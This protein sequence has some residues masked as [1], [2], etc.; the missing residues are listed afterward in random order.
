MWLMKSLV[1]DH[2]TI[3]NFRRDNPKAIR[4]VFRA[5][6]QLAKHFDLIGGK[7]VAGDS[8]KLRAQNSKKNNFNEAKIERHIAYI[9]AK[10]EEYSKILA[11][12]D[13]E[14]VSDPEKTE[15]KEKI[16]KH[17]ER[18]ATYQ[19]LRQ[20]LELSG[21]TQISTSDPESRQLVTRNNIT[22]VGYSVQTTVD[23]KHNIPID[24]KV[25]NQNDNK[26]MGGMV[27]RAKT[28]LQNND[29]TA[30]YD[31]GYHTGG[32]FDYAHKQGIEV[33]VAIPDPGSQAPDPAFNVEHFTYD[34]ISDIYTCPAG[35]TLSSN[36][37]QYDKNRSKTSHKVKHYKTNQC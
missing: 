8:T 1:P 6:V 25:T 18:K 34:K 27:R 28:I 33:L 12:E 24:F 19:D 16:K 23:A 2:N 15:I 31:K 14:Q 3:S 17:K 10:L 5:T 30:L 4:R 13:M 37:N 36:G 29:F 20:Q 32:E 22:E 9:D 11:A 26:A 21:E 35:Q 7:L